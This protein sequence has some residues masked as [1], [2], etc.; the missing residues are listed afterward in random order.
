V[1]TLAVAGSFWGWRACGDTRIEIDRECAKAAGERERVCMAECQETTNSR[2]DLV[3][4]M[5]E[6]THDHEGLEC[7]KAKS[8]TPG[9]E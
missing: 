9:P 7:I 5:R 2:A 8:A 1:V 3:T 6:C 4:C